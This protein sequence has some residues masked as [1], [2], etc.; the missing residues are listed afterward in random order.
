MLPTKLKPN[1]FKISFLDGSFYYFCG[2]K[3]FSDS[4]EEIYTIGL[5]LDAKVF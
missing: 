3:L 2:N 1:R 4:A 5:K